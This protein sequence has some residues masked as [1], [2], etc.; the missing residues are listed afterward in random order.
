MGPV[1]HVWGDA[2][3]QGRT[4]SQAIQDRA[5]QFTPPHKASKAVGHITRTPEF[6]GR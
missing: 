5:R 6:R 1:N 3:L 2:D 4:F